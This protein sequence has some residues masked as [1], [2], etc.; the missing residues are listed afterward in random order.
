MYKILLKVLEI[1]FQGEGIMKTFD[2]VTH[3]KRLR[4]IWLHPDRAW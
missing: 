4:R 3:L 2:F 1:H